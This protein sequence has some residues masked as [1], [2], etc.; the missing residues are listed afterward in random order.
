[1][2]F[3]YDNSQTLTTAITLTE[4]YFIISTITNLEFGIQS[5]F[6]KPDQYRKIKKNKNSQFSYYLINANTLDFETSIINF[7]GY[8]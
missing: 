3:L 6:G 1:M 2:Y 8:S 4:A 7:F 5:N